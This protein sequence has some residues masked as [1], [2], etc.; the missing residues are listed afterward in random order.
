[1]NI[2]TDLT[3]R[4]ID[5]AR[6]SIVTFTYTVL[7]AYL[8]LLSKGWQT[9][10]FQMSRGQATSVTMAMA[11]CYLVYSAY[12]LS[13]D[14]EGVERFMKGMMALLYMYHTYQNVNNIRICRAMLKEFYDEVF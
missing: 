4:Y 8:F 13:L 1:V 3:L 2:Q 9:I 7:L 11:I 12:F 10:S 14:F 6:V 5:M